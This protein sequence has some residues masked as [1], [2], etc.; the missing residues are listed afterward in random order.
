M[1]SCQ[2]FSTTRMC[3]WC[4]WYDKRAVDQHIDPSRR[5]KLCWL[6]KQ[7]K[8]P[9][10]R[11]WTTTQT[12]YQLQCNIENRWRSNSLKWVSILYTSVTSRGWFGAYPSSPA[13]SSSRPNIGFQRVLRLLHA[14]IYSRTNTSQDQ[15]KGLFHWLLFRLRL[16]EVL[17]TAQAIVMKCGPCSPSLLSNSNSLSTV[18]YVNFAKSILPVS[19]KIFGMFAPGLLTFRKCPILS[20]YPLHL[21][22]GLKT[23]PCI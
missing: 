1:V 14:E 22:V 12:S 11:G 3:D 9:L 18:V 19:L 6:P 21:H 4:N 20:Y 8:M 13:C 10:Q 2:A 15:Y 16:F 5:E 23:S 7:P 17:V